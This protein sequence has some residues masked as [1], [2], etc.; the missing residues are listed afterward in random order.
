MVQAVELPRITLI[1]ASFYKLPTN[2]LDCGV[3]RNFIFEA[4]AR[5]ALGIMLLLHVCN[6]RSRRRECGKG[7]LMPVIVRTAA[8]AN[9]G[10]YGLRK[11]QSGEEIDYAFHG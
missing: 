4:D 9:Y 5:R 8:S 11:N 2:S 10:S 6:L 1:F 7:A 3:P